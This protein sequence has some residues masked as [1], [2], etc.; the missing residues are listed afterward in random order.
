MYHLQAETV[1]DR[2]PFSLIPFDGDLE[3]TC[4]FTDVNTFSLLLGMCIPEGYCRR[5][6]QAIEIAGLNITATIPSLT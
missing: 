5:E 3:G 4:K 6:K 1:K 2:Q